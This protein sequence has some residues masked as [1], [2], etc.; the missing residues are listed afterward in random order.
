MRIFS[1]VYHGREIPQDTSDKE[2]IGK[3]L[4][5][6]LEKTNIGYELGIRILSKIGSVLLHYQY[7]QWESFH[8]SGLEVQ[9]LLAKLEFS[10]K[11]SIPEDLFARNILIKSNKEDSYNISFYYS[12]IRDYVICFHSFRLDN[13]NDKQFYELLDHFYENHIGQSAISFYIENSSHRRKLILIQYKKDKSLAYVKSYDSYL[14]ENFKSFKNK[15]DPETEGEI[16]I[17]L[18]KDIL[19]N[20]GYAL[21]PLTLSPGTKVQYEDLGDAFSDSFDQ[22]LFGQKGIRTIHFGGNSLLTANQNKIIKKEIYKQLKEILKKGRIN[23]YTSDILLLEQV[24][25]ITYFYSKQLGYDY[26]IKDLY[27]PRFNLIYPIKLKELKGKLYTFRV[28]EHYKR[29]RIDA[30]V[31]IERINKALR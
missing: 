9:S 13:L 6:S 4:K 11:E 12:K 16:G 18:P 15:F 24:A 28:T 29:Q 19:K 20:D 5:L 23:V 10:L 26:T 2:L 30:K 25:T 27:M 8:D 7:S 17:I 1:E 14:E 21:F 3:Y 22:N 31:R